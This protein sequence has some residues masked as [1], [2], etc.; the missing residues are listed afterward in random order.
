MIRR[1]RQRER[2]RQF[3]W[4]GT[5]GAPLQGNTVYK[6]KV[7]TTSTDAWYHLYKAGRD[8]V[9]IRFADTSG[10]SVTCQDIS[11]S[12]DDADGTNG[13]VDYATLGANNP[14]SFLVT[15]PGQYYIEINSYNCGS[16][17]AG[18]T[19]SIKPNGS[20]ASTKGPVPPTPG[21]ARAGI[22][23]GRPSAPLLGHTLYTGT[24]TNTSTDA[25]Y[26]LYK[27]GFGTGT[28]Y[29][30]R[31]HHHLRPQPPSRTWP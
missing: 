31:G 2:S 13:N 1:R 9:S 29:P 20:S 22:S 18:A 5:V 6:G 21:T 30:V 10:S 11:I 15:A 4:I 25:W 16:G 3:R 28:I 8:T 17:T 26:Q 12:L 27:S 7:A 24:V 14:T 19:Y 23:I